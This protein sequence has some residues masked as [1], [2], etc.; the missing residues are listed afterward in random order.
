LRFPGSGAMDSERAL[1]PDGANPSKDGDAKPS[2]FGL[3]AK[4]VG[5]PGTAAAAAFVGVWDGWGG[6]P[7]DRGRGT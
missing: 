3:F 7:A 6:H 4:A 1:F 5:L 2:A